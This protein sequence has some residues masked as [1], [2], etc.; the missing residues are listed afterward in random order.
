VP[1]ETSKKYLV[2]IADDSEDDSFFLE[3]VLRESSRFQ[4]V[5]SVRN[6]NEAIAYLSGE[7]QYADRQL[8]PFPDLLLLDLKMPLMDGFKVLEWRQGRTLPEMKIVILSGSSIAADIRRIQQLGADAFY[9]KTTE[10]EQMI[11]MVRNLEKVLLAAGPY[12][13]VP[14]PLKNPGV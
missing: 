2:L 4:V 3:R 1:A 9:V 5:G 11:E 8:W 10:Y 13:E 12:G 6:G 14:I 7:G